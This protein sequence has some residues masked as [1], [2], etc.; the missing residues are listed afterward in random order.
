[1]AATAQGPTTPCPKC[2][3][4]EWRGPRYSFTE[5]RSGRDAKPDIQESLSYSCSTCNYTTA[6]PT[7]DAPVEQVLNGGRK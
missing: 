1:M 2:G 4:P 5:Y 3:E 6:L 7:L